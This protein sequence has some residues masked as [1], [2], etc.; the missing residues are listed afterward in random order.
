MR[1]DLKRLDPELPVPKY[2]HEGDAGCDLYSAVDTVIGPGERALVPTGI[3]I[4]IPA[5]YGG[6]VQPKSGLAAK[7]GISIVNTPG[8]IDC[9]YRGEI[10]VI[11]INT[12]PSDPFIVAKGDKIAQLVIQKVESVTFDEVDELDATVRGAGGFGSTGK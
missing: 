12:D 11:L 8:L 5:G 10:K 1:I 2:A 7:Y 6:F 4:A 3:A 9:Q